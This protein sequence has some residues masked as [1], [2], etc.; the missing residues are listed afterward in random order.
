MVDGDKAL[1]VQDEVLINVAEREMKD[2]VPLF[3]EMAKAEAESIT[4]DEIYK[5][6]TSAYKANI[7]IISNDITKIWNSENPNLNAVK[8]LTMYNNFVIDYAKTLFLPKP[9]KEADEIIKSFTRNKVPHF[10]IHAKNKS[11]KQVDKMNNS[12]VNKLE[13]MIPN[14]PIRF[15]NIAGKIKYRHFMSN[16][17]VEIDEKVIDEYLKFEKKKRLSSSFSDYSENSDSFIALHR[18]FRKYVENTYN[19]SDFVDNLI[20]HYYKNKKST[21][22]DALWELFGDIIFTNLEH[23]IGK[24]IQCNNCN[25]RVL[26]KS[27][28]MIYCEDCAREKQKEWDR[29]Y[30][31]KKYYRVM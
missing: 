16:P 26:K 31:K 15:Q 14:K 10:F 17:R 6:L 25:K 21:S 1:V 24:T 13:S 28:R 12:T 23:N 2:I 7:G 20:I 8:W 29:E 19:L 9:P 27:D 30:Q 5:S 4:S 18:E 3:Y 11:D 22:K